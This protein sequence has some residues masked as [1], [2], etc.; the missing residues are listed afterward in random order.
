MSTFMKCM[1]CFWPGVVFMA[2][3]LLFLPA[4]WQVLGLKWLAFVYLLMAPMIGYAFFS[5]LKSDRRRA[6]EGKAS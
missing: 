3:L 4:P 1:F 6:Q 5:D 2:Y